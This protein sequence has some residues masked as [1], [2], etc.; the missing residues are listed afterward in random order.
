[1]TTK[2][3]RGFTIVE[4]TLFLAIGGILFA[5]LM[6]GVGTG[7]TQQRYTE[8]VRSY[9]ALLQ[10]QYAQVLNTNINDDTNWRC[11]DNETGVVSEA[12]P[13]GV[14]GA[15]EC[16]VLGRAIQVKNNG[17]GDTIVTS[18]VTGYDDTSIRTDSDDIEAIKNAKPK[19]GTFNQQE[20]SLDWGSRLRADG[21]ASTAVILILR[22]PSSGLIKI[23]TS[24]TPVPQDL[25]AV[26]NTNNMAVNA[27]IRM[28]VDGDS[29]LLPRQVLAINPQLASV[30]TIATDP[31]D[32]GECR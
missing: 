32:N 27:T 30:D 8:S 13:R 21:R 1:M 3:Q 12:A 11:E 6:V 24:K 10:D 23:F 16:V 25:E 15:S 4:T 26:I 14:R 17:V 9:K 5:A 18:S 2:K 28:C 31:D 7:I 29:G 22:S 20:Q 19:L